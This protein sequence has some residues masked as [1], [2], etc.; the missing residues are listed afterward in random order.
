MPDRGVD[1]RSRYTALSSRALTVAGKAM[2]LLEAKIDAGE[3]TPAVLSTIA[4][5]A[6]EQVERL[7]RLQMSTGGM[8]ATSPD[9]I[10]AKARALR[11]AAEEL[12]RREGSE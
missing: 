10:Q 12:L 3:V 1:R 7:E 6:V 5:K 9:E 11:A 4:S 2:S 8:G